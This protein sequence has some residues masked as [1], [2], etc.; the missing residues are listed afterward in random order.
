MP[1]GKHPLVPLWTSHYVPQEVAA[2]P[3]LTKLKITTVHCQ[4][5]S[6]YLVTGDGREDVLARQTWQRTI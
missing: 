5:L 6:T 3:E 2:L 4:H 1:V